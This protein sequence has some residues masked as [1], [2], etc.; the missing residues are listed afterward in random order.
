MKQFAEIKEDLRFEI[1]SNPLFDTAPFGQ[2]LVK[3]GLKPISHQELKDWFKCDEITKRFNKTQK[4]EDQVHIPVD[5]MYVFSIRE[6]MFGDE[7]PIMAC[8]VSYCDLENYMRDEIPDYV[9]E[10]LQTAKEF[11]FTEFEVAYPEMKE[12]TL[13]DPVLLGIAGNNKIF[14]SFWE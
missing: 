3:L 11:G 2:K 9:L 4:K 6:S 5:G 1:E 10:H 7:T 13:P 8:D 14:I 12:Q